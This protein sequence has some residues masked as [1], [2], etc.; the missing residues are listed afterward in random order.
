MLGIGEEQRELFIFNLKTF[1]SFGI[2]FMYQ[3]YSSISKKKKRICVQLLGFNSEIC[4]F[5]TFQRPVWKT[6]VRRI[7]HFHDVVML[8]MCTEKYR[9][10]LCEQSTIT[11]AHKSKFS[12][13][14]P[15][16]LDRSSG[17]LSSGFL[18][19]LLKFS[20]LQGIMADMRMLPFYC[21]QSTLLSGCVLKFNQ[22]AQILSLQFFFLRK[23]TK[24]WILKWKFYA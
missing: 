21:I 24:L 19:L 17:L 23:R 4:F 6:S 10:S 18:F 12:L 22:E 20:F 7:W 13:K 5:K 8:S 1:Q 16:H 9:Q 11:Q 15:L 2:I 14:T 3:Y